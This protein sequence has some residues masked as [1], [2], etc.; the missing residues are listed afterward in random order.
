M[1]PTFISKLFSDLFYTIRRFPLAVLCSGIYTVNALILVHNILSVSSLFR[2]SLI[3]AC[4][5]CFLCISMQLIAESR[6]WSRRRCL[7]L[8]FLLVIVLALYMVYEPNLWVHFYMVI[9]AFLLM[10]IAPFLTREGDNM[11]VW[12]FQCKLWLRLLFVSIASIVFFL[13]IM[14]LLFSIEWLFSI[15]LENLYVDSWIVISALF[16]SLMTMRGIP[17]S[18][19]EKVMPY[20]KGLQVILSNILLPLFCLYGTLLYGYTINIVLAGTLPKGGVAYMVSGFGCIGILLYLAFYPLYS[21]QKTLISQ[22]KRF[23]PLLFIIPLLLFVTGIADRIYAYQ[24][25][26][27]RY[28]LLLLLMWFFSFIL[29]SLRMPKQLMKGTYLSLILLLL[30]G[31][32][33][34]WNVINL[35]VYT[36][37]MSLKKT[38]TQQHLLSDKQITPRILPANEAVDSRISNQIEY[39]LERERG[40][41]LSPWFKTMPEVQQTLAKKKATAQSLMTAMG[42]EYIPPSMRNT[43]PNRTFFS[44][45]QPLEPSEI[46]SI[47]GYDYALKIKHRLYSNASSA[48]PETHFTVH[49]DEKNKSSFTV[50]IEPRSN[51][52]KVIHIPT[53]EQITLNLENTISQM[54]HQPVNRPSL[55]IMEKENRLFKIK[56]VIESMQGKIVDQKPVLQEITTFL[57]LKYPLP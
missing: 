48:P 52:Y 9:A 12:S 17:V 26:E 34:P 42:I 35:S 16:A 13:G 31:A 25:T 6:Q 54:H 27:P 36:Q 15:K 20:P 47:K 23:F 41:I 45:Q 5:S 19:N 3:I 1:F 29:L 8:S 57:Y 55:L 56:L 22:F 4:V 24:L 32:I 49:P 37:F 10:F 33:G 14:L 38:L 18:F 50:F 28:T 30:I 46:L 7:S 39:I 40:E 44:Y 53:G 21:Q 43:N 2:R 11:A 51:Q